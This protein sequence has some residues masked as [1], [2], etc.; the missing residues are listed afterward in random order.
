MFNAAYI[1]SISQ[2]CL[3]PAYSIVRQ[4]RPNTQFNPNVNYQLYMFVHGFPLSDEF[5]A[6][7]VTLQSQKTASFRDHRRESPPTLTLAV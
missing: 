3:F 5:T 6:S 4:N 2:K 1:S 7:E